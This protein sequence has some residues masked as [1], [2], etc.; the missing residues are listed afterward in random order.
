MR[1][2]LLGVCL[3]RTVGL[4][5]LCYTS[6][7]LVTIMPRRPPTLRH[8]AVIGRRRLLGEIRHLQAAEQLLVRTLRALSVEGAALQAIV[9]AEYAGTAA[10][11]PASSLSVMPAAT[12]LRESEILGL[13]D[14]LAATDVEQTSGS[15]PLPEAVDAVTVASTLASVGT[16][17]VA[18]DA[19]VPFESTRNSG[20]VGSARAVEQLGL[21][22]M[23]NAFGMNDE[24]DFDF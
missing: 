9:A 23:R 10:P 4:F 17:C 13:G 1:N 22:T 2:S 3:Q 12:P 24:D 21:G 5:S 15:A 14:V 19:P 7:R 11:V 20:L 18:V 8:R 16:G 6:A